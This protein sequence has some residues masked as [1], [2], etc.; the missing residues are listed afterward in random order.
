MADL[1]DVVYGV[2]PFVRGEDGVLTALKPVDAS[3]WASVQYRAESAVVA[4]RYDGAIAFSRTL[5][6]RSG[7]VKTS[8]I[9]QFGD[10]PETLV[11]AIH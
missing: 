9:A 2:L 1:L 10:L 7:G 8:I 6:E 11:E 3:N 4:G 5:D